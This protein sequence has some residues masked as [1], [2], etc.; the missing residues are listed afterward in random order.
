MY[1]NF[2]R[3]DSTS[4][5]NALTWQ[6]FHDMISKIKTLT[7]TQLSKV[8]ASINMT[9]YDFDSFWDDYRRMRDV[10]YPN[11]TYIAMYTA[12]HE[13]GFTDYVL[14]SLFNDGLVRRTSETP[15]KYALEDLL[16]MKKVRSKLAKME[17]VELTKEEVVQGNKK[18]LV[19]DF[20]KKD[21]SLDKYRAEVMTMIHQELYGDIYHFIPKDLPPEEQKKYLQKLIENID[22]KDIQ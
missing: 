22:K 1:S 20:Y 4:D 8:A 3:K 18:Y 9:D 11:P 12:R 7:K 6:N 17:K 15:Y 19:L 14:K 5:D 2:K 13:H 10:R 21:R 16:L